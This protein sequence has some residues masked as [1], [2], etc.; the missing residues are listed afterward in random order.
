MALSEAE[1]FPKFS[2]IYRFRRECIITEKID[3]TNGLVRIEDL[4]IIPESTP[5]P[6]DGDVFYEPLTGT[7]FIKTADTVYTV[8]AGSRN[9]WLTTDKDNYGFASW[10]AGN[11]ADLV[12]LGPGHHYG[13]WWGAGVQR[14]YGMDRKIFSLFDAH[15]WVGNVPEN[16]PPECVSVVPILTQGVMGD[17]TINAA[18]QWLETKG[19]VA[20]FLESEGE[21]FM[22][23]EG[24]IVYHLQTRNRYK[25]LI[26]NDDVPKGL[27]P[28]DVG[29]TITGHTVPTL[30]APDLMERL[31][32]SVETSVTYRRYLA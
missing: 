12:Q 1:D 28:I 23:P 17:E 22:R 24:I 8:R 5:F 26:E 15:R 14:R 4:G 20:S 6:N 10:V 29:A 32:Q 13:E 9:R 25:I 30:G 31:R 18:L 21:H 2:K 7:T 16:T 3:G 27:P 11:A 19:S